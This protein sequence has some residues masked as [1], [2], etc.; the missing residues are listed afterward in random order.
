MDPMQ[1]VTTSVAGVSLVFLTVLW[2][3]AW[4]WKTYAM[5]LIVR[6]NNRLE[7]K[8]TPARLAECETLVKAFATRIDTAAVENEA[9]RAAVHKSMQRFDAIMRRNEQALIR[10]AEKVGEP[11]DESEYPEE[12]TLGEHEPP[13]RPTGRLTRPQ[14]R[15]LARKA[16][17]YP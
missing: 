12:I 9:F 13:Q 17:K 2:W 4:R 7:E 3:F 6:L 16:G 15:E 1:V 11:R 10:R 14:L 5:D 8:A